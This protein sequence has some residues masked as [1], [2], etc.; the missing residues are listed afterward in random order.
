MTRKIEIS[1]RS[2]VFAILFPLALAFLWVIRELL[3]SLL[4]AFI[5]M[6]ALRPFVTAIMQRGLPRRL[7]V[8]IVYFVF[9]GV[10]G[11]IASLIVPPIVSETTAFV[12]NFPT[13][14]GSVNPDLKDQFGLQNLTQYLPNVTENVFSLLGGMFSNLFFVLTTLFFSLYFLLEENLMR[15]ILN[16]YLS[17]SRIR[18]YERVTA[19]VE[20]RLTAWF[21]GQLTLMTVIGVVTFIILSLL[22]VRYALP[23][24]L[25]AGILEVV[26]NIGPILASIP[27]ITIG[28]ADSYF[29]GFSVAIAYF[30]IQQLENAFIVPVIMR[31]AV[32]V[33]PITTLVSLIVGGKIG[34]VLGVL[35]A[36]P[37]LIIVETVIAEM[38]QAWKLNRGKELFRDAEEVR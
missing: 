21:W 33:N 9:L 27:A 8:M 4:I 26:P 13:I 23:L 29:T 37:I 3:F 36:I 25:L 18:H 2:V 20:D 19:K 15:R 14:L 11:L 6:S 16:P 28:V 38:M 31:R 34:G 12:R 24:A 5:V 1:E 7:A 32:G 10:I 17:D 30:V 22:G 35:L